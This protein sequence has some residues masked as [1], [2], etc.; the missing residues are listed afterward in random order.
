MMIQF[1]SLAQFEAEINLRIYS[2]I[3]VYSGEVVHVYIH[4]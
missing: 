4:F 3:Y 2:E 1:F